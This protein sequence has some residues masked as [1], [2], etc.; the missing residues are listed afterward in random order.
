MLTVTASPCMCVV[1]KHT[2]SVRLGFCADMHTVQ[3][4][5]WVCLLSDRVSVPCVCVSMNR[6]HRTVALAL[7][8]TV[9]RPKLT[10]SSGKILLSVLLFPVWAF[11]DV[12]ENLPHGRSTR[13]RAHTRRLGQ[14]STSLRCNY[15]ALEEWS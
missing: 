14:G 12:Y 9:N 13:A 8:E 15:S 2:A 7:S 5:A 3:M 11:I 1:R 10:R 4:L 6:T